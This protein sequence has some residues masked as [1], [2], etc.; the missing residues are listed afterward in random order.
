MK[1]SNAPRLLAREEW[2]AACHFH[3]ITEAEVLHAVA[4]RVRELKAKAGS[5]QSGHPLVLLDLDSTLYE[6]GP[7]SFE[8]IR[9]WMDTEESLGHSRVRHALESLREEQVG[10][11]MKD[12]FESIGLKA[13]TPEVDHALKVLKE[14]WAARFF[15]NQYLPYDRPYPGAAEFARRLHE[16]GAEIVYLTGRDAPRMGEGTVDNLVRDGFPW[17]KKGTHLL[18]KSD[19]NIPDLDHKKNAAD[20]IRQHGTLV[21]SFENEPPNLIALSEL[22]PEAMHVFLDTVCSDHPAPVGKNLYRINGFHKLAP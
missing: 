2:I 3:D 20:Y 6:V 13:G 19:F 7:R 15:S 21:A 17:D 16:A 5:V 14:F 10:Y 8:I 12:T 9:E 11:S 1:S 18:L 4:D 22:F